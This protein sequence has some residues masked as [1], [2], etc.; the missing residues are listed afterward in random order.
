MAT[1]NIKQALHTGISVYNMQESL[2]WYKKNLGF[3]LVKDDGYTPP[4]K[5]KICFIEHD[6]YQIELFE[7]D[8]PKPIPEDRLMPNT[9]LQTVG[10]KHLALA[11]DDMEA[12]KK[13]FVANGV[14]I[15]HEVHMGADSVMF[16]RDCNGVLIELIQAPQE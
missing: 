9:D 15:A 14:D 5:A 13:D 6:G 16:I 3:E 11:V 7:Y 12:V 10:T 2:E 4:L 8:D 1:S